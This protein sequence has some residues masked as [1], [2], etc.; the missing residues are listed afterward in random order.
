MR[1]VLTLVALVA[2]GVLAPC[3]HAQQ[4]AVTLDQVIDKVVSQEQAEMKMLRE[5]SPLVETYIQNLRP[6]KD[7]GLVPNGDVYFLGRA[8]L[9]NGVALVPF[10]DDDPG[11]I[12][13]VMSKLFSMSTDFLPQGFLQMIQIDQNGFDRQHYNFDFV[14]REFLGEVRCLVFDLTPLPKAG[15]GRFVGRIWVEDQDYRIVRFNGAFA[16]ASKSGQSFH[17][18]SWRVN[19]GQNQ[20]FP[21]LIYTGRMTNAIQSPRDWSSKARLVCGATTWAAQNSR[22]N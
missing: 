2:F 12:R 4:P 9:K 21:A 11:S 16:G 18:D 15:K 8:Q 14:R 17:F 22:R 10:T 19:A 6:D 1:R 13:K 3:A 5:Y 20:W 7:L